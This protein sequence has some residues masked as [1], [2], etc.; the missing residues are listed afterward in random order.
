MDQQQRDMISTGQF[1]AL[2][3][4]VDADD[5]EVFVIPGLPA[6]FGSGEPT[7]FTVARVGRTHLQAIDDELKCH[8]HASEDEARECHRRNM[9]ETRAKVEQ[10]TALV[11]AMERGDMRGAQRIAMEMAQ[12]I[13]DNGGPHISVQMVNMSDPD[14]TQDLSGYTPGRPV[15]DNVP[16]EW[17]G[18]YL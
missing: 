9:I 16:P 6:P 18:M 10:A 17:P 11:T 4:T 14:A 12:K 1:D 13:M 5:L 3:A 15:P 8:A 2:L 7:Q